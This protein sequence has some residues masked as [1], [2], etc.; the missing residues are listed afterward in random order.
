MPVSC[1]G[2]LAGAAGRL[3]GT[4]AS[5]WIS[6]AQLLT[7]FTPGAPAGSSSA[8]DRLSACSEAADASAAWTGI[9]S[10]IFWALGMMSICMV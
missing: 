6:Q 1:T 3:Q 8:A 4:D 9:I 7:F 5:Y 10:Q 2:A